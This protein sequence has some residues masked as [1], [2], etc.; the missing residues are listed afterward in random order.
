MR[1]WNLKKSNL[2]LTIVDLQTQLKDLE[3]NQVSPE[4]SKDEA[5]IDK[6]FKQI[7]LLN[8]EKLTLETDNEGG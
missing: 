5:F 4:S 1:P 3:S 8:D 7:D 2:N 6:L